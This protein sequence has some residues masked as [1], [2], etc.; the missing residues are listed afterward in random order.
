MPIKGLPLWT[1]LRNDAIKR[2]THVGP[3]ILE[4][5]ISH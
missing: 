4:Y 2:I 1:C 3:H 5:N